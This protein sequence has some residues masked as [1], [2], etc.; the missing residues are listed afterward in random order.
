MEGKETRFGHCQFRALG[1]GDHRSIQRF[2]QR[3]AR[4]IHPVGRHDADVADATG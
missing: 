3:H 1:H 2:G 4:F